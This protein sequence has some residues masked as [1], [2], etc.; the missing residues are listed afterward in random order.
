MWAAHDQRLQCIRM[1]L[2]GGVDLDGKN[3]MGWTALT[4]AI[5]KVGPYKYCVLWS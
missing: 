1:L 2:Q 4:W 5:E 3:E